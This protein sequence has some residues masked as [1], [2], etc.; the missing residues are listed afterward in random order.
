MSVLFDSEGWTHLCEMCRLHPEC[1]IIRCCAV[2]RHNRAS[3]I[4][5]YLFFYLQNKHWNAK[6]QQQQQHRSLTAETRWLRKGAVNFALWEWILAPLFTPT[7]SA[8]RLLHRVDKY[9]SVECPQ[10]SHSFARGGFTDTSIHGRS[11]TP[12]CHRLMKHSGGVDTWVENSNFSLL[13]LLTV[14]QRI[15]P[16]CKAP[17]RPPTLTFSSR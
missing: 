7:L 10:V 8:R 11:L 13:F 16:L 14:Y 9:S 17:S 5:F 15:A 6:L 3:K 12:L 2:T 1:Q 4:N